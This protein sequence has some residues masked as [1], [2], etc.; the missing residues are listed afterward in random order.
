MLWIREKQLNKLVKSSIKLE[1]LVLITINVCWLEN[2]QERAM[3]N[4][5]E[6]SIGFRY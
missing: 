3:W 5:P 2:K 1:C 4:Y 6:K